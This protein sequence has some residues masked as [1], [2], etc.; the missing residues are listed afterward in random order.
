[1]F[2]YIVM[3][4]QMTSTYW[5][6]TN[7][8][9]YGMLSLSLRANYDIAIAAYDYTGADGDEYVYTVWTVLHLFILNIL[10]LNFLVSILSSTYGDMTDIGAFKFKC[11]RF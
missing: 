5:Q 2:S 7:S 9:V 8:D 4:A 3:T 1:M 11:S 10:L 6:D